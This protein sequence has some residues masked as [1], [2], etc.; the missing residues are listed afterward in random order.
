MP[1][2]TRRLTI[3]RIEGI[4]ARKSVSQSPETVPANDNRHQI[5][6]LQPSFDTQYASCELSQIHGVAHLSEMTGFCDFLSIV[7]P[8]T[9]LGLVSR[10]L[11]GYSMTDEA[12]AHARDPRFKNGKL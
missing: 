8:K 2:N 3:F 4:D 10:D 12:Q 6:A 7:L 5:S 1:G 11:V 9:T